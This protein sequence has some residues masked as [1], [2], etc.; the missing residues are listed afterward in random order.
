MHTLP[1]ALRH[2]LA[3]PGIRCALAGLVLLTCLKAATECVVEKLRFDMLQ[4]LDS[5]DTALSYAMAICAAWG[6]RQTV[7][8]LIVVLRNRVNLVIESSLKRSLFET[9]WCTSHAESLHVLDGAETYTAVEEGTQAVLCTLQH[10]LEF[11]FPLARMLGGLWIL[12][13]EVPPAVS[14]ASLLAFVLVCGVGA[15]LLHWEYHRRK[16]CNLTSAAHRTHNTYLASTFLTER[17]NGHGER[18]L[19]TILRNSVVSTRLHAGITEKVQCGYAANEMLSLAL[20]YW[21][22]RVSGAADPA[23]LVAVFFLVNSCINTAWWMF[24][25]FHDASKSAARWSAV[26]KL[27]LTP[28][29]CP[30]RYART[31]S[32]TTPASSGSSGGPGPGRAP[33]SGSRRCACATRSHGLGGCTCPSA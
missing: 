1:G 4:Q 25:M 19:D 21:L 5:A 32:R 30:P 2:Q 17:I 7:H 31:A 24:H 12:V 15:R 9:L 20:N 16:S 8:S 11:F 28:C 23:K 13:A 27:L 26:Q 22:V 6:V 10:C 29:R 33:G 14:A 18:V 3:Q